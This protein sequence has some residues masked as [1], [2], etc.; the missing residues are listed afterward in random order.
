MK[1]K[2]SRLTFTVTSH[3]DFKMGRDP[4]PRPKERG[5][6]PVHYESVVQKETVS[7]HYDFKTGCDPHSPFKRMSISYYDFSIK[8]DPLFSFCSTTTTTTHWDHSMTC[9]PSATGKKRKELRQRKWWEKE[10]REWRK[11]ITV[12]PFSSYFRKARSVSSGPCPSLLLYGLLR[13]F[14]PIFSRRCLP[15]VT[16]SIFGAKFGGMTEQRNFL[17]LFSGGEI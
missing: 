8:R 4:R 2:T 3:Y 11:K 15:S 13:G 16:L 10:V 12:S 7:L 6:V 1:L 5:R 9:R 17:S 14:P